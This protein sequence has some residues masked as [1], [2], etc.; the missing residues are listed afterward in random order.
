MTIRN[1]LLAG[2]ILAG[3]SLA[4]ARAQTA[5][6]M[7]GDATAASSGAVTVSKI[8]GVSISLGGALATQGAYTTTLIVGANTTV[9]LPASGTLAT[10]AGSLQVANNLS[11]LGNATTAR[12]N[13]GLGGAAILNVGTAAGNVAAGTALQPATVTGIVKSS[14][15][16]F[17]AAALADVLAALGSQTANQVLAAPNGSNGSPA[18]RALVAADLPSLTSQI[19]AAFGSAQ[20]DILYRGASGW[21]AL[22][23]G[24]SGQVLQSGGSGANPSWATAASGSSGGGGPSYTGL[25]AQTANYTLV[26]GDLNKLVTM[27]SA[28]ALTLTLPT[29]TSLGLAVG[30]IIDVAEL[31]AGQVLF[32]AGTNATFTNYSGNTHTAGQ[33]A[34]ARLTAIST[35]AWLLTGT[36]AP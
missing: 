16:A 34:V 22:P 30:S 23:P 21:A 12:T 32:S 26:A 13:L 4:Q 2:S 7:S 36:T 8:G 6:T 19:D 29:P 18:F 9:T 24:T 35:I 15:S 3:L 28:S 17:S 33:Y 27:T 1:W 14:G 11:D 25:D 10:V 20:G 5:V 31:G